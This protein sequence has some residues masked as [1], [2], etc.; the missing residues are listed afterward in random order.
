MLQ[1]PTWTATDNLTR[2]QFRVF[3]SLGEQLHLTESDRRWVL[4]LSE[5]EWTAQNLPRGED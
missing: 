3:S 4:L 1:N 2:N 5:Q